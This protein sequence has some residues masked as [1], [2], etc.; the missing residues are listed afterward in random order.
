MKAWLYLSLTLAV[1]TVASALFVWNDRAEL[2]PDRVPTHWGLDGQPDQWTARDDMLPTLLLVPGLT[3]LMI[4]LWHL[5]PW[6]SPLKFK[7]EPFRPT[8]D[9]IMG[10][11]VLLFAYLHFVILLSYLDIIHDGGRWV[12]CGTLLAI[13]AMGNVLGKVGRNF[14]VGV[15]TPWTLA[16]EAVWIRTHRLAAW[17]FTGCGLLGC[18]LVLLGVNPLI[19]FG[20]LMVA[21][22]TPVLYSL[23]LYKQL[24]KQGRLGEP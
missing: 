7:I 20:L 9:Y 8:Y 11:V 12:I 19:A 1:L 2:L 24:E 4:G 3:V 18:T 14:W 15:R 23:W 17:L 5:L 16:S 13:A 6:L 21:A 22:L 10:V